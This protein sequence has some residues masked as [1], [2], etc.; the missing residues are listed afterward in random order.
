MLVTLEKDRRET[1]VTM[2]RYPHLVVQM[3]WAYYANTRYGVVTVCTHGT[4]DMVAGSGFE[5]LTNGL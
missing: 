1:G 2:S 5:P 3:V 4:S